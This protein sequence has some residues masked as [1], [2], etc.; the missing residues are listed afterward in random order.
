MIW[1]N[2]RVA[3][4]GYDLKDRELVAKSEPR[5]RGIVCLKDDV[6]ERICLDFVALDNRPESI[7][8]FANRYG[9]LSKTPD[10]SEPIGLWQSE[11]FA[12]RDVVAAHCDGR[13]MEATRMYGVGYNRQTGATAGFVP[14]AGSSDIEFRCMAHDLASWIWLETGHNL[15]GRQVAKCRECKRFFF[16]GGGKGAR[17]SQSRNTRQFCGIWCKTAHNNRIAMQRKVNF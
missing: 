10:L 5:S 13:A 17:R 2:W 4:E 11:I 7:C 16:K 14:N 6:A 12:V 15:K 1:L 9:F 3:D 8:E